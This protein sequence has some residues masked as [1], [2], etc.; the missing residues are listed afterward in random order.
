M[1]GQCRLVA[2]GRL[3]LVP[4]HRRPGQTP[5]QLIRTIYQRAANR[6]VSL[7]SLRVLPSEPPL[8]DVYLASAPPGPCCVFLPPQAQDLRNSIEY[9][10]MRSN[11]A[12]TRG[13]EHAICSRATRCLETPCGALFLSRNMFLAVAAMRSC[14]G[15]N[16][17]ANC[18]SSV[19]FAR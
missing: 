9:L 6:D 11:P 17:E 15:R 1:V 5:Q 19:P 18:G 4:V 13:H 10:D 14:K 12:R 2:L 7:P 16:N 8:L 3:R